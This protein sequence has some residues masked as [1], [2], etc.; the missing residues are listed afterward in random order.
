MCLLC[1]SVGQKL[2]CVAA[3]IVFI[4]LSIALQRLCF[5]R[6]PWLPVTVPVCIP[7]SP[8]TPWG[9]EPHPLN[10]C[11]PELS[12]RP[13]TWKRNPTRCWHPFFSVQT[14]FW[15][16][17]LHPQPMGRASWPQWIGCQ[18]TLGIGHCSLNGPQ[19]VPRLQARPSGESRP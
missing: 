18:G 4:P 5:S 17:G 2:R 1:A 16:A 19:L 13:G 8:A 14:P 15:P 10:L 12:P 3:S 6:N 7:H 11:A 9:Q